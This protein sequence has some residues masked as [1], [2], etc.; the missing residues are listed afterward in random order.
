ML[1]EKIDKYLLSRKRDERSIHCF[2]P[3]SLHKPARDLYYHYLHG[4][5]PVYDPRILRVFDNGHC[6]HSRL[7][8]YLQR[9]GVLKAIE[10]LVENR[11]YE[12][13]GHADG[14]IEMNE[15]Q[16]VLEIKSM[17]S[18]QFYSACA[19][20]PEHLIQVNI[21]MFCLGITRACILYECKDDQQ[22]KEFFVKQDSRIL[23]PVLKKIKYVQQCIQDKKPPAIEQKSLAIV[24]RKRVINTVS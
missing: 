15:L 17:N 11:E 4:D 8:D 21:Y 22:L 9:A 5:E 3:S 14:I 1:A 23:N 6:V 16:G 12:I 18:N 13:K 2:H 7:Q 20:K 24:S 10:V 19:P